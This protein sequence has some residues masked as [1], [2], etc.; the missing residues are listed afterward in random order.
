LDRVNQLLDFNKVQRQ[1]MQLRPQPENI[2]SIMQGVAV[3]FNPSMEQR[4]V[5]LTAIY[6]P[7]DF[8]AVVDREA[9]TKI[10]SNLMN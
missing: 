6:P 9:V 3:R 7:D 2:R 1:S 4:G 10:I 5:K 8:T